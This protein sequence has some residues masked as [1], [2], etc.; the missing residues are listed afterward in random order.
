MFS[1]TFEKF[2]NLLIYWN[3]NNIVREKW[4]QKVLRP[5][6][7]VFFLR[8]FEKFLFSLWWGAVFFFCLFSEVCCPMVFQFVVWMAVLCKINT[9]FTNSPIYWNQNNIARRNIWHKFLC[10]VSY[11]LYLKREACALHFFHPYRKILS[12]VLYFHLFCEVNEKQFRWITFIKSIKTDFIESWRFN[13]RT[14]HD[15]FTK[16]SLNQ[17][18]LKKLEQIE[19]FDIW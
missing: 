15:H 3:Q 16:L 13:W 18:K 17:C 1:S 5:V 12:A 10:P 8:M 9:V 4:W 14:D 7:Y 2:T 6:S 19:V 11:R